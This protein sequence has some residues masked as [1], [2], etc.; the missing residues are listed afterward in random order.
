M[1]PALQAAL[2]RVMPS[3]VQAVPGEQ[4]RQVVMAC[5]RP[6]RRRCCAVGVW[7]CSPWAAC[8]ALP[9][10]QGKAV[11]QR[12]VRGLQVGCGLAP[13]GASQ[14]HPSFHPMETGRRWRAQT[15]LSALTRR[16]PVRMLRRRRRRRMTG[17]SFGYR[18][19]PGHLHRGRVDSALGLGLG[20]QGLIKDG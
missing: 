9:G 10:T 13:G 7:L 19:G 18:L 3:Y 14:R 4:E 20:V 8:W 12:K 1:S 15:E 5:W 6:W 17:E 2:A 11:L 16:Q